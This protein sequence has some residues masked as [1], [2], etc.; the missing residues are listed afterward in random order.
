MLALGSSKKWP[1]AL[2]QVTGG[3]TMDAQPLLDYFKPLVDW[4]KEQNK[5]YD[6]TWDEKCPDGTISDLNSS[7][8]FV[9][10]SIVTLLAGV[11]MTFLC[12]IV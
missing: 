4:L 10:P 11:V 2:E 8:R 6:V 5:D 9:L 12:K 7:S 3:R 1:D